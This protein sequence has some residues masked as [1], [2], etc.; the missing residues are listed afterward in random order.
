MGRTAEELRMHP[1]LFLLLSLFSVASG[2]LLPSFS[3]LPAARLTPCRDQSAL[4]CSRVEVDQKALGQ[5]Q[6]TLPGGHLLRLDK[7][8]EENKLQLFLYS[9]GAGS[10]GFFSRR[11]ERVLGSVTLQDKSKVRVFQL[12]PCKESNHCHVWKQVEP[13]GDEEEVEVEDTGLKLSQEKLD[14]LQQKGKEDRDEVT[15]FSLTFYTTV[16]F[17]EQT[18]DIPLFVDT[19]IAD[20][21]RGYEDSEIGV[22]VKLPCLRKSP[23]S[24]HPAMRSRDMLHLFRDNMDSYDQLRVS[25]DAAQL[26]A[27]KF[28]S[29]TCGRGFTYTAANG[30][31]LTVVKKSCSFGYHSSGHELGHN[32]GC[33]H[34]RDHG[35]NSHYDYGYGWFIGPA[36]FGYRTCM[37]YS[38]SGYKTRLNRFSNPTL[39]FQDELT[40]D[41]DEAD[42]ARVIR[43]NRFI[44][45]AIGDETEEC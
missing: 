13:F 10:Q 27:T 32:F 3:S 14:Q 35:D 22:R 16:E 44:M 15:E 12:E 2:S 41:F 8:W 1:L 6:L 19:A 43:E 4:S 29:S 23:I 25:A 34:D 9:D 38:A 7:E 30:H 36:G 39:F 21:N 18:D 28:S 17:E 45:A 24:E 40:G 42:N 37:A 5:H 33:Q 26:L 20:M 31:T 11:S